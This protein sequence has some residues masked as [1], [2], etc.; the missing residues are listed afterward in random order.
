MTSLVSA[1]ALSAVAQS[2]AT[3]D[4]TLASSNYWLVSNTWEATS[5]DG[6]VSKTAATSLSVCE[7]YSDY[8][9][10]TGTCSV[11]SDGIINIVYSIFSS[12]DCTGTSTEYSS[13]GGSTTCSGSG[14]LYNN[15]DCVNADEPWTSTPA[16]V[17]MGYDEDNND[18]CC[19]DEY[20]SYTTISTGACMTQSSEYSTKYS[21]CSNCKYNSLHQSPLISISNFCC[22][23]LHTLHLLQ[24]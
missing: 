6:T 3:E 22:S 12:S 19:G 14:Y 24:C 21:S 9:Y 13:I 10:R 20:P 2:T 18:I 16:I 1:L 11:G 17:T 4:R 15:M 7:P 8:Q 5:C 23:C